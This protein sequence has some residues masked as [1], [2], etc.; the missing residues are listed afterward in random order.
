MDIIAISSVLVTLC[1]FFGYFNHRFIG[2]P[3]PIGIMVQAMGVSLLVTA[4]PAIG[5][6]VTPR[7]RDFI[8]S[9]DFSEALMD[10]MLSFLLFA[11]ALHVKLENL[12]AQKWAV[13][14]LACVG[15]LLSAMGAGFAAYHLFP[16][17]GLEVSWV[18]ALLFGALIAPTDP[19]AVM[20]ILKKAGVAKDLETKVVGESLFNDGIAVVLFMALL[21]ALA[22]NEATPGGVGVL[23][24]IEAGGGIALG[25]AL[26]YL[27]FRM[28]ATIDQYQV[29][30]LI[31]LALVMGGYQ[32]AMHLHLSGPITVV[33]AGLLMGNHGRT[34]LMS[35]KSRENLDNFWELCDEFLNAALFLLIGMEILI[36]GSDIEAYKA[37]LLMIPL[38]LLVRMVAV[39][40]PIGLL[41][42][43]RRFTKG[44]IPILTWGG[45]RG[46]V[47]VAL[48][49]ALPLS[50]E[51][52]FILI[53]TYCVV[54]FSIL[55]QGLTIGRL[56]QRYAR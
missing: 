5:I 9:I 50:A 46:G 22:G 18:Y 26:G 1:A 7:V 19:V 14:G 36:L 51:R 21:H 35:Q 39:A 34:N 55:V 56:V 4:L 31:T 30:I 20:A 8:A 23:F 32:L 48:A 45:L 25:L 6:D 41:R 37:G 27:A 24:L 52:D 28:L 38:L 2:L 16:F 43:R 49:L 13:A 33:V 15:T 53:V 3:M 44:A 11:G 10:G 40:M 42:F 54:V 47:S 12:R 29:E 17:F